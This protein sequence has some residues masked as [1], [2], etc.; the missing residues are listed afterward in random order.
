MGVAKMRIRLTPESINEVEM[1]NVSNATR[2]ALVKEGKKSIFLVPSV[3]QTHI[4]L[5][6]TY[7]ADTVLIVKVSACPFLPSRCTQRG[8]V[9]GHISR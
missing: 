6:N 2:Y 9:G 4:L 8:R 7:C 3:F 1:T 5:P